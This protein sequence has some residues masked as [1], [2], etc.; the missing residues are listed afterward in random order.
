MALDP[1]AAAMERTGNPVYSAE[2]INQKI[3]DSPAPIVEEQEIEKPNEAAAQ[4]APQ[5]VDEKTKEFYSFFE[6]K[7]GKKFEEAEKLLSRKAF[8]EEAAER[9]GKPISE[10]EETIKSPKQVAKELKSEYSKKLEDWLEKGGV[11]KE[12]HDIQRTDWE[13]MSYEDLVKADL[14]AKY[15]KADKAKIDI[16]FRSEF[17]AKKPLDPDSH[18][19]EEV[20]ERQEEIEAFN[21]RLEIKAEDIRESKI[22]Q[23]IKALEAPIKKDEDARTPAEKERDRLLAEQAQ[24][25]FDKT[26]ELFTNYKG[27]EL[28]VVEKGA[29]NKDVVS[30]LSFELKPQQKE[31]INQ[32]VRDPRM[33]P[34]LFIDKD[35][36]MNSQEFLDAVTL[37]VVGKTAAAEMAKDFK[38]EGKKE[39]IKGLKNTDFR[40]SEVAKPNTTSQKRTDELAAMVLGK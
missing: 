10:I 13:G 3:Q 29:D 35:G 34:S 26:Q 5:E 15:P 22:A 11:E 14:K 36:N 23:R 32:I 24:K 17:K 27:L 16:L 2:E 20:A 31:L 38:H 19:E 18:S 40:P 33:L 9:F 21:A 7:T 37:A 12:F 6:T 30:S 25:N 28:S 1:L 4:E 8:D 39:V